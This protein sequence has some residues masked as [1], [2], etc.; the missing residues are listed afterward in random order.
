M[1][2]ECVCVCS[3]SNFNTNKVGTK[4]TNVAVFNQALND[5]PSCTR[6]RSSRILGNQDRAQLYPTLTGKISSQ[7]DKTKL[8]SN[9]KDLPDYLSI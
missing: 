1:H 6:M 8:Q 7:Q 2:C 5:N 3:F 4:I 9:K